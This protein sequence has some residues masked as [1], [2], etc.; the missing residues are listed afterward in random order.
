MGLTITRTVAGTAQVGVDL[1]VSVG[2]PYRV[3]LFIV[4]RACTA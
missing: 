3:A 2:G 1:D 4:P